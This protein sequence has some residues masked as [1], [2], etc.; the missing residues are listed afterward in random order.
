MLKLKRRYWEELDESSRAVVGRQRQLYVSR[1]GAGGEETQHYRLEHLME[2]CFST[3]HDV[4]GMPKMSLGFHE[5]VPPPKG[6][7][8]RRKKIVRHSDQESGDAV[9]VRSTS[10]DMMHFVFLDEET[11]LTWRHAIQPYVKQS[12]LAPLKVDDLR[13]EDLF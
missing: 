7:P 11:C 9:Y 13:K 8:D 6:Q 10:E 5:V 2:C 12:E 3:P 1:Q 4:A